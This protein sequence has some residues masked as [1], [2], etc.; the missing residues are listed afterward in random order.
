MLKFK[1]SVKCEGSGLSE[2]STAS[3]AFPSLSNGP[4]S[5]NIK[6]IKQQIKIKFTGLTEFH[7]NLGRV[8]VPLLLLQIWNLNS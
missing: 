8:F 1:R 2:K 3:V 5:S 7:L 4:Q 6:T